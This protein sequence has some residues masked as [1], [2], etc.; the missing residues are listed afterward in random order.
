M[1]TLF[2]HKPFPVGHRPTR[3][4]PQL[5]PYPMVTF[6]PSPMTGTSRR[7]F[8]RASISDIAADSFCTFR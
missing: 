7:P 6:P 3:Q 8:V 4:T 2:Y 1:D 5:P